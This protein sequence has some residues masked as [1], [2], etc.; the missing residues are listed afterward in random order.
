MYKC[1]FGCA[2][3]GVRFSEWIGGGLINFV[4]VVL[5]ER[6]LR[7]RY[8]RDFLSRNRNIGSAD[9]KKAR[10]KKQTK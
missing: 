10:Q 4:C 1:G 6:S 8:Q 3:C 9:K 5:E 7:M 2:W